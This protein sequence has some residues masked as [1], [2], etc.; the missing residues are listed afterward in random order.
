MKIAVTGSTGL[1]GKYLLRLPDMIGTG[2]SGVDITDLPTITDAISS[3]RPDWIIHAAALTNVDFCERNPRDSVLVGILGTENVMLAAA[4]F[5]ARVLFVSTDSVFDG[6][7]GCYSET[8]AVKPINRYARHKTVSESIVLSNRENIVIRT[9]FFGVGGKS[10]TDWLMRELS[11]GAVSVFSDSTWSPIYAG[12]LAQLMLDSIHSG[13]SGIYH[14]SGSEPITK[15]DFAVQMKNI[16][17]LNGNVVPVP[18]S[19]VNLA[20]RRPKNTSLD[21][22]KFEANIGVSL[23]NANQELLALAKELGIDARI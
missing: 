22:R 11:G 3:I 15:Y 12:H 9:N 13:L 20:A 23:G 4:H 6:E 21:C 5:G 10:Y 14:V 2:G 8:D 19:S 16:L 7:K 18:V 1:L 17:G